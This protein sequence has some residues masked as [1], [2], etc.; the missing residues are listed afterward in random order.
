MNTLI[1]VTEL[2]RLI[3]EL[4]P[5][6][7]STMEGIPFLI[8]WVFKKDGKI[9]LPR[10]NVHYVSIAHEY[11]DCEIVGEIEFRWDKENSHWSLLLKDN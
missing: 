1:P 3:S 11:M 2:T 7:P 6:T 9:I 4:A 10:G 8:F 5:P